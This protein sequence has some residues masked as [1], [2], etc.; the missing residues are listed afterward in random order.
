MTTFPRIISSEA[1]TNVLISVICANNWLITT[2]RNRHGRFRDNGTFRWL[3]EE[4]VH[5]C[6]VADLVKGEGFAVDASLIEANASHQHS[7]QPGVRVDW[8]NPDIN[9]R[10]MRAYLAARD[11]ETLTAVVPRKVSLSDPDSRWTAAKGR[12]HL[13][14]LFD[15]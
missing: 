12:H 2:S 11:D 9:T 14:R 4:V 1:S 7:V 6:M 15:Q 10:A 5:R 13:F 8:T 3:F